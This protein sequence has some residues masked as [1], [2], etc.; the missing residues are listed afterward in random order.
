MI[1]KKCFSKTLLDT[2]TSNVH[3]LRMRIDRD[4]HK[5]HSNR[6][7]QFVTNIFGST[8]FSSERS[9]YSLTPIKRPPWDKCMIFHIFI[10]IL[11]LL[12]VTVWPDPSWLFLLLFTIRNCQIGF[13]RSILSAYLQLG[14]VTTTAAPAVNQCF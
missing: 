3:Q 1:K 13:F 7:Q 2:E 9:K 10:Y 12:R 5:Y 6:C 4:F 11:Q 8:C 14:I